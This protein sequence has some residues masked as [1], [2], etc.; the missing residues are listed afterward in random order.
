MSVVAKVLGKVLIKRILDGV[1][2]SLRKEQ[3]ARQV[4]GG[5]EVRLSKCLF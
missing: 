5:E 1:D 2:A 4:F 3:E